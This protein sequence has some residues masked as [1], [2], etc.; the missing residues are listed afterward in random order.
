MTA[1]ILGAL[2][3]PRSAPPDEVPLPS[4]D[5]RALARQVQI[6]RDLAE[7]AH[8][9]ALL[10]D[11]R[12]LGS[13]IRDFHS[14][15]AREATIGELQKARIEVNRATAI[16]VEAAGMDG[17]L[18]LRAVQLE[19][20]LAEVKS[21]EKAGEESAELAALAG[22]FVRRMRRE[23]W[24]KEKTVL[25]PEL[26]RRAMFK[27]MWNAF[28][29]MEAKPELALTLDETR[30]LYAFYLAHPHAPDSKREAF[31][32]ARR[33][34]RD[35]EACAALDAGERAEAERWRIDRINKLAG[36]DKTY[37]AAY[38]RGVALYRS[39]NYDASVEAFREWLRDHPDG[40]LA[41][42]AQNHLR[43]AAEA[44]RRP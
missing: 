3:L 19:A 38:A 7:K 17:L 24:I 9:E 18:K 25:L 23:G 5:V 2:M 4:V 1:L 34:A 30:V 20:F 27:Q 36:I 28:I 31:A 44:S 13:A 29:T 12:A 33:A 21:F 43:A 35:K 42:R 37:P 10:G 40:P 32:A 22:T 41:L 14:L 11:V 6:D 8:I 15:E 39:G 26:V 16:A